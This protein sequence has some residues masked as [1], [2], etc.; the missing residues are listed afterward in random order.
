MLRLVPGRTVSLMVCTVP[1]SAA[2][3]TWSHAA[4]RVRA[5]AHE[6]REP[7][8]EHRNLLLVSRSF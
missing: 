7:G 8:H 3:G 2:N 4:L 6:H 5:R 1:R